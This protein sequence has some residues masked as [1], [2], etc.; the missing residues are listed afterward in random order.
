MNFSPEYLSTLIVRP[1]RY[2]FENYGPEDLRWTDDPKTTGIEIDT[3]NN[4]N[5]LPIQKKPRILVTRGQYAISPVG[6]TDNLAAGKGIYANKGLRENTNMFFINGVAQVMIQANNE[7]TCE[8]IVN[9][10]QHFIAWTGP[11]LADTY[12]FKNTFLPMNISP[13]IPDK[14]DKEIFS[15]TINLP[16]SKEEHWQVKSGDQIKIKSFLLE[17]VKENS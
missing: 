14:E 16:Y 1:L 12:G 5:K 9:L 11:M 2:L 10:T 7:G 4:F 15:C 6:L 8:K 13:C 3:I 17:L